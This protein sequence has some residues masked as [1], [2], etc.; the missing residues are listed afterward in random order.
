MTY[1]SNSREESIKRRIDEV[2]VTGGVVYRNTK[3]TNR[4]N[5]Q[6]CIP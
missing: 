6:R 2:I 5:G 1:C 4:T 3:P